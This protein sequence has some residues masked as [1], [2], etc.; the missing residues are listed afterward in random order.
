MVTLTKFGKHIVIQEICCPVVEPPWMGSGENFGNSGD[1]NQENAGERTDF[2][3][4]K[5]LGFFR[6]VNELD[7]ARIM[8]E[9]WPASR[10]QWQN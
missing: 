7:G 10:R 8:E 2:K 4:W 5:P 6:G 3:R 1:R 9:N